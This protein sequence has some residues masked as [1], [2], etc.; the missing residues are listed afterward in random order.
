V[1]GGDVVFGVGIAARAVAYF[2]AAAVGSRAARPFPE[3]TDREVEVLE[4]VGAGLTN[5]D[6]ARRLQLS[7]KTVRNHVSSVF[8]KLQVND[9][10]QAAVRARAAGLGGPA[11]G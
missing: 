9:R 4:L 11:A 10:T 6:I 8:A 1:A 3:L 2:S 7:D 5:A